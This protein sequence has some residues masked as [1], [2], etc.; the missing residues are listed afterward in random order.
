[1]KGEGRD[2]TKVDKQG[3]NAVKTKGVNKVLKSSCKKDE[4]EKRRL[5]CEHDSVETL[6]EE[7]LCLIQE[8]ISMWR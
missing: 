7:M 6:N 1:M 8:E 4:T 3:R 2:W 5:K